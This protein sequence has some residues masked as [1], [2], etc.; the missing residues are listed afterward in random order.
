MIKS[1]I[2]KDVE[3]LIMLKEL[4][5]IKEQLM[6][7]FALDIILFANLFNIC[8]EERPSAFRILRYEFFL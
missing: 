3:N 1:L 2:L 5:Y 4:Y 8:P 6:T 7:Q